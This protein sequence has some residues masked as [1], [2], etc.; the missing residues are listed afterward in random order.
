MNF[1]PWMWQSFK[2]FNITAVRGSQIGSKFWI[3]QLTNTNLKTITN[4]LN[5]S[6]TQQHEGWISVCEIFPLILLLFIKRIKIAIQLLNIKRKSKMMKGDYKIIWQKMQSRIHSEFTF[7]FLTS[8]HHE[9]S[10]THYSTDNGFIF[11]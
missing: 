2:L 6:V 11:Q 3:V 7:K 4:G 10:V 1:N 8:L 9:Q 5:T